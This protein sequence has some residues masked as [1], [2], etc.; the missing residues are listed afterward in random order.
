MKRRVRHGQARDSAH[1]RDAIDTVPGRALTAR[2]RS[3]IS[4][5]AERNA[6]ATEG[7]LLSQYTTTQLLHNPIQGEIA[8][9]RLTR[10]RN[11]LCSE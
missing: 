6:N 2:L 8:D 3:A 10:V 11:P 4:E 9:A 1:V 7:S 5:L